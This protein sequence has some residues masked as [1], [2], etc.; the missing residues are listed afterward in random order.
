MGVGNRSAACASCGKRL[1]YKQWYYRNGKHY[2]TKRCWITDRDKAAQDQA[3]AKASEP[4]E[5]K[6]PSKEPVKEASPKE[7]SPTS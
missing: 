4:T 1:N 2:C 7:A 5:A 6:V 3:K